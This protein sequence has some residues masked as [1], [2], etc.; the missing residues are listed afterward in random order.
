V[1]FRRVADEPKAIA[2]GWSELEQALGSLRGRKFYGVFDAPLREYRVCV[3]SRAGDDGRALGLEA[4]RLPGGRYACVRPR[5][6]PPEVYERIAP[7]FEALSRRDDADDT[8]PGIEF[9]RRR[10]VID[11]LLPVT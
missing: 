5:G 2:R 9:D 6:E 11:L 1:L 8:R 3:E 4:G 10:D 7:T